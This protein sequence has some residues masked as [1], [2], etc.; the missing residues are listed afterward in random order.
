M[1]I[2]RI[3]FTVLFGVLIVCL[4]RY[5]AVRLENA[6]KYPENT[7]EEYARATLFSDVSFWEP[8]LWDTAEG[9]ITGDIS[10]ITGLALDI[11]VPVQNMDTQLSLMLVND[12]LPDIISITNPTAVSQLITSGKVWNIEE[13]FKT[14]KPDSHLLYKF[15]EDVKQELIQR[16]GGWYAIP[17][18]INSAAARDIWK[19][20]KYYEEAVKYNNNNAIIWNKKLL[21]T[22]G[23]SIE[24]LQT[25]QEVLAAFEKVKNMN[26]EIDGK[27]VILLLLDGR[28]YQ[29]PT[30]KFLQ[31]TFGAESIDENGDYKDPI[32]QPETKAALYFLNQVMRN[33][34][35]DPTQLTI[36]NPQVK[37]YIASGRVL[38]FIGNTANAEL[39]PDAWVSSGP[40]LSSSGAKPVLGK[41]LRAT[42]G[43]IGTFISKNC[44]NPKE[45][46]AWIDYMTSDEGMLFWNYGYEGNDYYLN[47][48]KQIQR[49]VMGAASEAAYRQTGQSAWWMFS[50][51]AWSRSVERGNLSSIELQT[52]YGRHPVT[53]I[54]DDSLLN[55][56]LE[57]ISLDKQFGVIETEV[58]NWKK[59]QI[60]V[61]ILARDDKEFNAQYDGFMKR[62]QE[63]GIEQLDERKNEKYQENCREYNS[64]IKKVNGT[65]RG[66]SYDKE[67]K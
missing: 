16:D 53:S 34:Y 1:W 57:F 67:V 20:T 47:E 36:D 18:H 37:S 50:N 39:V 22:A 19:P 48:E 58:N 13:F 55:I 3:G 26:L 9:T 59:T 11:T 60:P 4:I 15:P 24:D 44:K 32:L 45:I 2:K 10:K 66:K 41:N 25:D 7:D 17:S 23:L 46:A 54:Y 63:L 38:C 6:G 31:W 8:P 28:D 14:Y 12:K 64:S 42:T 35:A 52:A 5:A 27:P 43:W 65:R 49:T 30:L 29:D 51:L 40:I 61:V 21:E 62:L 33:S 56:P